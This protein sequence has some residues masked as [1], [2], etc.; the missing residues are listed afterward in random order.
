MTYFFGLSPSCFSP[1]QEKEGG[2][3]GGEHKIYCRKPGRRRKENISNPTNPPRATRRVCVWMLA[4]TRGY[5]ERGG[6]A[7]HSSGFLKLKK[8]G[9][10]D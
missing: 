6:R 9:G 1:G 5:V 4:P 10:Q 3:G 8:D 2:G 7:S